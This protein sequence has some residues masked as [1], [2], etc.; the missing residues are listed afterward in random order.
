M[1]SLVNTGKVL[2][3]GCGD[4]GIPLGLS[5][6]AEG[7]EVWGLCRSSSLPEPIKTLHADVTDATTLGILEQTSFEYVIL[8]LT[9]AA[10]NDEGYRSV[11]VEGLQNVLQALNT[12]R[13]KRVLFVSSSS[14]YHQ[15]NGEWVDE[16]SPT[17]PQS[18]SGRRLLEAEQLLHAFPAATTVVRFAGIYGPGRRRLIEQVKAGDS[19][20][21]TPPLYTNR[22][23]R[24]DCVGFLKHLV[25]LDESGAELEDCYLGVDKQPVPMWDVK[26]WLAIQLGVKLDTNDSETPTRRNSKRC[27][28]RRL[29]ASGYQ[30]QFPSFKD[31]YQALLSAEK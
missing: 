5:L 13:L 18:F 9:P 11:F 22:I 27:S 12:D 30:L 20:A 2:L 1:N 4:I 21:E 25:E 23:H 31:G 14:V 29:L 28:N 17:E 19:C 10:F 24:D 8:T 15:S 16:A 3:V 6:S 26:H 7:R